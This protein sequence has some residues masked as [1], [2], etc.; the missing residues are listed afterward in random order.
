VSRSLIVLRYP[1][2]PNTIEQKLEP[3][4][5]EDIRKIATLNKFACLVAI[6][7]MVYDLK[8]HGQESRFLRTMPAF[9]AVLELKNASRGGE[10]GG[11]RVYL[12]RA[13][14]NEYHLCAA[15]CKAAD[16]P[17]QTLLERTAVIAFAWKHGIGIFKEV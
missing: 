12:Y 7:K 3:P 13:A 9:P 5:L 14:E 8:H 1:F 16:T 2:D 15:E 11:A 4:I 17:N 10:A 6:Q